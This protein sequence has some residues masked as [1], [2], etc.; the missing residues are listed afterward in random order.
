[1]LNTMHPTRLFAVA[2]LATIA[3][4]QFPTKPEGVTILESKLED[5]VRISYKEV[6]SPPCI[7]SLR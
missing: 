5:G 3:A 6:R 2:G 4:A 1:M 7:I